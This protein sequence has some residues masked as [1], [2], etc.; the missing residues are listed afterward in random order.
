MLLTVPALT[1]EVVDSLDAL[2]A[3]G[4]ACLAGDVEDAGFYHACE[5]AGPEGFG[6]HYVA[7]RQAERLVAVAPAFTVRYDLA[8]TLPAP[9]RA[10]FRPLV[11]LAPGLMTLRLAALGSP[12]SEGCRVGFAPDLPP[13]RHADAVAAVLDGLAAFA[14]AGGYGLIGIKDLPDAGA[15]LW[16][17]PL[18]RHGFARLRGLPTALLDLP[19]GGDPDAYLAGL[20]RAT[21]KDLRR[22]ARAF[23]AAGIRIERRASIADVATAVD[24]LYAETLARGELQ[25]ERLSAAYFEALLQE[26][27][28]IAAA[29]L[30]WQDDRL[31]AFNVILETPE[32]LV[33]K[34]LGLSD[35]AIEALSPYYNSWL[36]NVRLCQSRG[37]PLYHAGQ[38][39]YAP[40]L[41]LGC[42]LEDNSLYFR[43]RNALVNA[44]LRL[45]APLLSPARGDP[46]LAAHARS[47]AP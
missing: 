9:A 44:A 43:H 29:I 4:V 45:V 5:K 2:G 12:V 13:E 42:R 17:A 32:R 33:D 8:T 23:A 28:P 34:Y 40:K 15:A 41:R 36:H 14:A 37:I 7:V 27:A 30:Y 24:A 3:A 21:R 16:R 35:A 18:E 46:A 38:S 31:I 10:L 39:L 6:W 19:A 25:F 22:K 26:I 47:T 1:A 11:A 20:S